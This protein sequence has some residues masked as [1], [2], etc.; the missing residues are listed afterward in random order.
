M[1]VCVDRA[2]LGVD[3]GSGRGYRPY[4]QCVFNQSQFKGGKQTCLC[5]EAGLVGFSVLL[6]EVAPI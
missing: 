4:K 2:G 3:S 6:E 1:C 5:E